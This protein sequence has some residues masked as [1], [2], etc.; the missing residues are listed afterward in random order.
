MPTHKN[1]YITCYRVI[2]IDA[3]YKITA[4]VNLG[5]QTADKGL[6][7]TKCPKALI[8]LSRKVAGF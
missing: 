4:K 5:G 1:Q 8:D 6:A 3:L 7:L 2:F